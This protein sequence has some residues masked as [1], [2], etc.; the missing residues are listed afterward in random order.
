MSY[1]L[2]SDI[3]CELIPPLTDD[4]YNESISEY[5]Q[6]EA[7]IDRSPA[8]METEFDEIVFQ[9]RI[10]YPD[11]IAPEASCLVSTCCEHITSESALI[12]HD[13]L[14]LVWIGWD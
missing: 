2:Q 8:D 4:S 14:S 7:D 12:I 3:P 11:E 1:D 6:D 10:S 5:C 13:I 9:L